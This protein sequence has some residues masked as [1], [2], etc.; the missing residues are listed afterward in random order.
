MISPESNPDHDDAS[1]WQLSSVVGGSPGEESPIV[2]G[3][4]FAEWSSENG[5]IEPNSDT[6][7]D[8]RSALVE[9][10]MGTNPVS[11][12][13]ESDVLSIEIVKND[14]KDALQVS[15][16]MNPKSQGIT[17]LAEWSNDLNKWLNENVER[18]VETLVNNEGNIF[19]KVTFSIDV[20]NNLNKPVFFRIKAT[21][22]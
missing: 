3:Q 14:N 20:N 2:E 1:N 19:K 10:A 21:M 6:D 11:F 17:L 13:K 18:S 7:N 12:E 15:V 8:G 4:T 5:N 16:D 22:P 9:F